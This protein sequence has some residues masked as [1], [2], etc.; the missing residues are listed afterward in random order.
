MT[1]SANAKGQAKATATGPVYNAGE[2]WCG[3]SQETFY[4]NMMQ[5][6]GFV[7]YSQSDL[8]DGVAVAE[9]YEDGA[10]IRTQKFDLGDIAEFSA[11]LTS[12]TGAVTPAPATQQEVRL[13]ISGNWGEPVWIG[14]RNQMYKCEF[15]GIV[16]FN[17]TNVLTGAFTNDC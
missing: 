15:G 16:K 4:H 2:P 11:D 17:D 7:I 6:T 8:N 3:T 5:D 14:T 9:Y 10:K 13:K 1:T 12:W